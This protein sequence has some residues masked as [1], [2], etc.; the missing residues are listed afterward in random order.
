MFFSST[1]IETEGSNLSG[2]TGKCSWDEPGG[3][4]RRTSR[5]DDKENQRLAERRSSGE[6]ADRRQLS[7]IGEEY[8]LDIENRNGLEL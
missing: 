6:A 3:T 8:H 7:K 5:D 2:V 1:G 4:S